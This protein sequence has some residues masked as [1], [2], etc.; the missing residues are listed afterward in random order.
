MTIT[1]DW[2][3]EIDADNA[4]LALLIGGTTDYV[5]LSSDGIRSMPPV[6]T[7]DVLRS[8]TDGSFPGEDYLA[9]RTILL[10]LIAKGTTEADLENNL[11][12]LRKSLYPAGGRGEWI[13]RWQHPDQGVRR[14]SVRTRAYQPGMSVAEQAALMSTVQVRL[15]ATDPN[16]YSDTLQTDTVTL[17]TAASGGILLPALLPWSLTA[18]TSGIVTATNNGSYPA[19]WSARITGPLTTPRV[20]ML[21]SGKFIELG[22]TLATDADFIDLDSHPEPT[23]L[24][25]GTASRYSTITEDS[26]WFDLGPGASHD[27]QLTAASGTG[28]MQ[29]DWRDT[30]A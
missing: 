14:A 12:T 18:S 20:T 15:D 5:L 22:L 6:R 23:A 2:E 26:Q 16:I 7:G 21:G 17:S 28:T 30:Y 24:L 4:D 3:L 25:Q 8:N 11:E 13:L 1:A 10:S 19:P 29:F 9:N 27:I